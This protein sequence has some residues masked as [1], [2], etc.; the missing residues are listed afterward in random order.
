MNHTL[1]QVLSSVTTSTSDTGWQKATKA[2]SLQRRH[3][4][5][6]IQ[7]GSHIYGFNTLFGQLDSHSSTKEQQIKLLSKHLVGVPWG[8][9]GGYFRLLTACKLQQLSHAQTGISTAAYSNILDAFP[10]ISSDTQYW[11]DWLASYGSGD[12]VP[13]SWWVHC[14]FAGKKLD[15][16]HFGDVMALINGNFVSVALSIVAGISAMSEMS[17]FLHTFLKYSKLDPLYYANK[18]NPITQLLER[19]AADQLGNRNSRYEQLPVSLRDP[20]PV[21]NAIFTS[22]ATLGR[23]LEACLAQSSGNPLFFEVETQ[24]IAVSQSSFL[25]FNLTFALTNLIQSQ[26]LCISLWQRLILHVTNKNN[27]ELSRLED[28]DIQPP[29]V[30]QALI[31]ESNIGIN[32]PSRFTG[33]DS[34]ETEDLRDLSL[35]TARQSMKMSKFMSKSRAIWE[36]IRPVQSK[37]NKSLELFEDLFHEFTGAVDS[38]QDLPRLFANDADAFIRHV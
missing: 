23:E 26:S 33:S 25:D 29:K 8:I 9:S 17:A 7:S 35:L 32:L 28:Y 37:C 10:T 12:V 30:A 4:E 36:N 13:A 15:G 21:L 20:V 5:S 22:V 14:L 34:S 11:G 1:S 19:Y 18:L 2:I 6:A 3:V 27:S 31:E 16:L 38:T 24:N